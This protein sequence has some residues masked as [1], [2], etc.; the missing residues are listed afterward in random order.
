[1]KMSS[2]LYRKGKAMSE[3][4][5]WIQN[6]RVSSA[7][8]HLDFVE[9]PTKDEAIAEWRHENPGRNRT[10]EELEANVIALMFGGGI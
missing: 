4:Q 3:Y 8:I 6:P 2:C 5:L 9:A 1:M 7:W 10:L